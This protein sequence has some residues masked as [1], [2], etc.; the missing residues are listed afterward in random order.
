[1]FRITLV[2]VF[3][4]MVV[5]VLVTIVLV[6]IVLVTIVLVTI[7]LVTMINSKVHVGTQGMPVRFRYPSPAMR[8]G[9]SL[10]QHEHGNEQ[11]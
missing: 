4:R 6:T 1:V 3:P 10:P 2:A 8:M 9:Q 5:T 11:K 7:V